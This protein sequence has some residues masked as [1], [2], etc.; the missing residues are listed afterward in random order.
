MSEKNIQSIIESIEGLSVVDALNLVKM[1]EE[2]W[3]VSA[4]APVAA[5]AGPAE[6]AVEKTEW[7]VLLTGAGDKKIDVM[8]QVRT[9]TN[10]ELLP[11]KEFVEKSSDATPGSLG[12]F[13]KEKAE[14]IAAALKAVGASV[15]IA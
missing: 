15:K 8:K 2:K 10:K 9:I 7:E 12:L 11:A 5:A 14:E 6:A 4:A 3:G 13:P 1:C